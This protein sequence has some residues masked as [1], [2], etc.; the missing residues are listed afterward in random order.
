MSLDSSIKNTLSTLEKGIDPVKEKFS[1]IITQNVD[2]FGVFLLNLKKNF[3]IISDRIIKDYEYKVQ[4]V[5]ESVD[6]KLYSYFN[7]HKEVVSRDIEQLN[8]Q[9]TQNLDKTQAVLE[10]FKTGFGKNI[11]TQLLNYRNLLDTSSS[12]LITN[13]DQF[14]TK[15]IEPLNKTVEKIVKNL[16]NIHLENQTTLVM[17][18]SILT[19]LDKVTLIDIEKTWAI[20]SSESVLD[21][22][23]NMISRT[24]RSISIIV[25]QL[26]K[27]DP[28][29]FKNLDPLILVHIFANINSQTDNQLFTEL[30]AH[31][32]I[33]IWQINGKFLFYCVLK[34]KDEIL[35]A[36]FTENEKEMVGFVTE[37]K[38]YLN[39]FQKIFGPY[40]YAESNEMKSLQKAPTV[41]T[42]A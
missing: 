37:Q 9:I 1:G 33:R 41:E 12:K 3:Q 19:E 16:Q 38:E 25:P 4:I 39:A 35:L 22:M 36:P 8:T 15:T 28:E 21:Y 7:D 5:S 26:S 29:Y 17:L 10:D 2:N 42:T 40:F 27:I 18:Q 30:T 11:D 31:K 14:Q 32:N 34:D 23:E 6:H 20:V 13:L 24:K